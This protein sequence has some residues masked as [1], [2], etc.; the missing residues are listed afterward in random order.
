MDNSEPLAPTGDTLQV[1]TAIWADLLQRPVIQPEDDFFE[2][3]GDSM[4]MSVVQFRIQ[5]EL[6]LEVS[7][8]AIFEAPTLREFCA[9][10]DTLAVGVSAGSERTSP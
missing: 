7:P 1:V 2:Q 5:E 4:L 6:G 8:T 9:L 3:G 10:L